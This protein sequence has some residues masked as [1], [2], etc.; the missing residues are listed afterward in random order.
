MKLEGWKIAKRFLFVEL[1]FCLIPAAVSAQEYPTRPV[2][3]LIQFAP[4]IPSEVALRVLATK[5][6]KFLGQPFVIANNGGGGGSVAVGIV[7]KERPDGYHLLGCSSSPLVRIPHFR[8]VPYKLGDFVPVMHFG[9]PI[10]GLVVRADSPWKTL[11]E[12]VDYAKRNPGKVSYTSI[13]TGTPL[14]LAMEFI[15]KQ[16]G[17]QWTHVPSTTSDPL[18]P[19][20]GGHVTACSSGSQWIPHI[21]AGTLRLLG[22]HGEKRMKS[23]PDVPTFQESGYDF[24]NETVL[25]YAV[26]KGTPP[27]VVRKLED[28]FRKAM[29]EPEFSQTMNR[30]EYDITY[31]NSQDTK[32]YLEEA[33]DRIGRMIIELKIPKEDEKK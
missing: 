25:L 11:K 10:S 3:L 8:P 6:E 16:E 7:A 27:S 21:K 33:Y 2:N 17:I 29:D 23:F 28:A 18:I 14:H 32:K 30:I 19:L 22:T 13:G 5:A 9:A 31:R 12:F 1:L 20:L 24:I 26:P 4:G 15:A